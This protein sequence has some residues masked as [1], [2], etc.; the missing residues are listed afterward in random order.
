MTA[1]AEL[2]PDMLR[3]L[4]PDHPHTLIT[5]HNLAYWR[6]EAGDVSGA[7]TAY[8]ELLP[9]MLRVLGPDHPETLIVRGELARLRGK[10][11]MRP[12]L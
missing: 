12:G 3:V 6:E 8:A 11:G 2:L 7:A 4:G 1:F 10:T 5:R 9:V